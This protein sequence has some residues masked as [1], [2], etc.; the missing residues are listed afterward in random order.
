MTLY[1]YSLVACSDPGVIFDSDY[2]KQETRED[3]VEAG[4]AIINDPDN[5]KDSGNPI[6]SAN[7]A[8]SIQSSTLLGAIFF[9]NSFKLIF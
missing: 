8:K 3:N 5:G 6:I 7:A 9:E 2:E 4:N 1:F